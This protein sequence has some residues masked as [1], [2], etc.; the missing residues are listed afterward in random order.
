M[1]FVYFFNFLN[2]RSFEHK[3]QGEMYVPR[4]LVYDNN[5]ERIFE[6][7]WLFMM[8]RILKKKHNDQE[9]E[10]KKKKLKQ[11]I[12]IKL[13][14][15]KT[16]ALNGRKGTRG[17]WIEEKQRYVVVLD[18]VT[19]SKKLCVKSENI[20]IIPSTPSSPL[21]SSSSSSS[22]SGAV[23][24]SDYEILTTLSNLEADFEWEIERP[25]PTE[26]SDIFINTEDD[27]DLNPT[28]ASNNSSDSLLTYVT[29]Q[30][31]ASFVRYRNVGLKNVHLVP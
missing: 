23:S 27:D 12:R 4:R 15:L 11:P 10:K 29:K 20:E 18:G 2:F 13:I 16:V 31:R 9:E 1:R 8:Y 30:I 19:S 14:N 22:S 3:S 24:L 28:T 25:N 17:E 5:F 7:Q 26:H 6:Y 21:S